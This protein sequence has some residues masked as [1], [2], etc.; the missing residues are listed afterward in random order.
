MRVWIDLANSP[1]VPLF[2]PIVRR[3]QAEGAEIL[4]SAR[5]HAQ[6]LALARE[7]WP[8]VEVIGG[9]SPSSRT[10]K[11]SAIASRALALRRFATARAPQVALSHG[12]YAQIIAARLAGVPCVTMMDYEHQP[13]NHLSFRLATRV[14]VPGAFPDGALRR[15]GARP[16]KVLRYEGFKEELYLTNGQDGDHIRAKLG[17]D[18]G[19]VLAVLRPPPTGALY[20]RNENDRFDD[21][22]SWLEQRDDAVIVLLPRNRQQ[23]ERYATSR[24]LIPEAPLDGVGLLATADFVVGGGGTMTREAA[25]LGT[26]TYTVFLPRLAAVD[27]ELMRLGRIQDLRVPGHMPVVE[28][29]RR[30]TSRPVETRAASICAT[31]VAALADAMRRVA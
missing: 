23:H 26:P 1:H 14:V 13:A 18:R 9:S 20:A 27:A 17:V 22:L 28:K 10:R 5:D 25:L 8:E 15:F 7:S 12:S 3:L 6:T 16:G 29:K 19:A 2:R 11:A 31:V 30:T 4:L 21:V 24:V